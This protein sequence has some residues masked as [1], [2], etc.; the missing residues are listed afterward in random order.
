MFKD[1]KDFY[2][3]KIEKCDNALKEINNVIAWTGYVVSGQDERFSQGELD[4]CDEFA[5]NLYRAKKIIENA[6]VRLVQSLEDSKLQEDVCK[7]FEKI[8]ERE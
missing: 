5:C 7:A 4:K 3:D 8:E 2:I 6:R 1:K